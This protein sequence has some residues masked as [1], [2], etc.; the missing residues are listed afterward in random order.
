MVFTWLEEKGKEEKTCLLSN[1]T[2]LE[3][4]EVRTHKR[5]IE[6]SLLGNDAPN[7]GRKRTTIHLLQLFNAM[8]CHSRKLFQL[9]MFLRN[10][11]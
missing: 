2:C 10:A 1:I 9:T 7:S 3:E 8:P 11:Y 4:E 6:K 5:I